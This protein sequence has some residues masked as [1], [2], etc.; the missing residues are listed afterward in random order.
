MIRIKMDVKKIN[1]SQ[2]FVGAKGTYMDLT[3][4]DNRDGTDEY[5]NDGFVVQDIGKERREAGE[6]G[7]IVGNWK[8]IGQKPSPRQESR[9]MPPAPEHR[10][11]SAT[12]HMDDD[13]PF[14][15]FNII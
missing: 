13:I 15:R 11:N 9:G 4:M 14:A 6:K 1:K 2:L 7:P 10:D 5:G 8:H 3:L 12:D